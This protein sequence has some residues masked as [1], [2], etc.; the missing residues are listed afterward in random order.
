MAE[1]RPADGR[2]GR[3]AQLFSDS[4]RVAK[5]HRG[6]RDQPRAR[7]RHPC[8]REDGG[9]H[10]AH[11]ASRLTVDRHGRPVKIDWRINAWANINRA[12]HGNEFHAHPGSYWSGTYYVDDGGI[13][14]D[15]AL[16]GEF[17]IQDPRGVGPAMYAPMLSFAMPGGQSVGA[18]ELIHPRAGAMIL[19]PAWLS[20]AVR[21]YR[22]QRAR[23]SVAFNLSL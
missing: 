12:G 11:L 4:R 14:T 23:I 2:P 15:P 18:N 7:R 16:G 3:T 17:E 1:S 6:G 21:P 20:H 8:A 9:R 19:F 10:P 22:G 13:A 5:S